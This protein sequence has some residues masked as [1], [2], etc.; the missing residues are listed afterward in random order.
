MEL[1]DFRRSWQQAAPAETRAALDAA[2]LERLLTRRSDSPVAKMRRNVW[3]EIGFAVVCLVGAG[4]G[5]LQVP[6]GYFQVL[7]VWLV[8]I[9]LLSGFYYRRKLAVLTRLSD[10]TGAVREQV[11]RQLSSLRGL[12]RLYFLAT[13]WSLPV[14]LAI[15][16]VFIVGELM[17]FLTGR[18][19]LLALGA[20]AVFYLLVG[21]VG[22][23]A[24]R[25]FTRWYLQRLYGQH[26]DHLETALRELQSDE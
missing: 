15:G 14:S 10:T 8:L 19:L 2:A 22:F 13:M 21:A 11:A 3:L 4:I 18:K 7:L 23:F 9:C 25:W 20:L 12:V 24:I 16:P 6:A 26:L 17:E 5:L 1:D